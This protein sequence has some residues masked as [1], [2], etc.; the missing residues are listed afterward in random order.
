MTT[1]ISWYES[2]QEDAKPVCW[3]TTTW[4]R[5]SVTGVAYGPASP[6]V[7]S[8]LLTCVWVHCD[9]LRTSAAGIVRMVMRTLPD[10]DE[11]V[12]QLYYYVTTIWFGGVRWPKEPTSSVNASVA[13]NFAF[14]HLFLCS[15]FVTKIKW[16]ILSSH[17]TSTSFINL[18]K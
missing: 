15:V 18:P 10:S 1:N 12:S 17:S 4:E 8:V 3:G 7:R 13:E 14:R 9:H 11:S 5:G 2:C 16:I 6:S